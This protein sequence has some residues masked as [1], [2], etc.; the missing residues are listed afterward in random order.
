[1]RIVT[2]V[3]VFCLIAAGAAA[4]PQGTRAGPATP[5]RPSVTALRVEHAPTLDGEVLADPAWKAAVPVTSF[6]QEQPEEGHPASERTEVRLVYTADTLYVGVVCFDRDPKS[7]IVSD[8]RRD[9]P[10]DQTDSVQII[11]DTYRDRLN[12]F[13][14]GTNP[15]GIEYDGQVTNEGQGGGGLGAGQGQVQRQQAGS[16]GGF[17][18]NWDGVWDVR[19]RISEIGWSAEFAIP[20]RTLRY[21]GGANQTWGVNFQ[22][23]IRRRNERSY[24]APISR[25]YNLYRLSLAGS[26]VGIK[27]PVVRNLK[28]TPYVLGNVKQSGDRPVDPVVLGQAGGDLKYNL[29]PSL[30]LDGTVN[31]DFAQVEVD[32]QQVNLDRFNLFFPEKRPF[33][34]EN[35][36]FFSVGNPGEVDLFFSRQIGIRPDT[37]PIPIAGGARVSGKAGK[38][39]I[40]LLNMQTRQV[41]DRIA[42][43]NFSVARISRDL[44]NRSSIGGLFVN[45]EGTGSLAR[46][47]DFNRTFA[48]DGKAGIRDHT[49][50]SSFIAKTNTPGVSGGDHAFNVR[51]RTTV[52]RFDLELGYQEVGERFNPE[53]SFL[54]RRGYRKPDLRVLTRWRPAGTVLQELRP[55]ASYRA[56]VGFDGFLESSQWHIDNHWQF[57]N[58][59][60]V[61]TGINLT[62]EGVRAPFEIFP[63]LFVPAG[64]YKHQEAQLVYMSNQGAPVSLELR[65]I[66]GG[67]FGGHRVQLNPTLRLRAGDALTTEVAY[68]RNDIRLPWGDFTTNLLRVRLS[69]AF[70]T[71]AFVQ[72]LVQYNDRADLWSANVRLGWLR[73]GN[74]GLFLVYTDTRALDDLFVR[75]ARTDRSFILK[76]S[77][78]FDLLR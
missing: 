37:G 5:G 73:S 74:T 71:H 53:V 72:G 10:L 16:G 3:G 45:R 57:R 12:G 46:A 69:Y 24:W 40:G 14:F 62:Q 56:F 63:K 50:L 36:G 34:L 77:R 15:A 8:A 9:A 78:T 21:P 32:D 19:T 20:F 68:Q 58:S 61:H 39:N 23:N 17:N 11:F 64:T 75:P 54:S 7:I 30:T 4:A 49:V 38:F 1:M 25:Q 22:R 66:L 42:A 48:L 47:G 2:A 55:H 35:A 52:P 65:T 41:Q 60:E 13:V 33:F 59:A 28:A 67:Y 26:L 51:S 31:T 70:T 44:P 29:T 43:N 18:L 27:T 6:L 76:F